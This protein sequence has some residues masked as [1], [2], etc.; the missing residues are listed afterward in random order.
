MW[1]GEVIAVGIGWFWV[2][3]GGSGGGGMCAWPLAGW[4][5]S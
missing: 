1:P 5:G 3:M 4:L 2:L